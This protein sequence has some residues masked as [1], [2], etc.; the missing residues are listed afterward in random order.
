MFPDQGNDSVIGFVLCPI[1]KFSDKDIASLAFDQGHDAVVVGAA[2][3]SIDLPVPFD[4]PCFNRRWSA[5]DHALSGE[6]PPGVVGV[7]SF[8]SSLRGLS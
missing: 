4:A 6:P 5:I 7:V 8:S 1:A 2:H 3:D